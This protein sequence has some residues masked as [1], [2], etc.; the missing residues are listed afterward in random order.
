VKA[1][2][3][4]TLAQARK[5]K[6]YLGRMLQLPRQ[7][8]WHEPTA[9]EPLPPPPPDATP[10]WTRHAVDVVKHPVDA[11]SYAILLSS[12]LVAWAKHSG[13]LARLTA[14]QRTALKNLVQNA[15]DIAA[16]W[17]VPDAD[18]NLVYDWHTDIEPEA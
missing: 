12:K 7:P 15:G 17:G 9:E 14:A 10:G 18:G 16:E 11:D 13:M 1:L 2:A 3:P 5:I 6:K 4:L 8:D